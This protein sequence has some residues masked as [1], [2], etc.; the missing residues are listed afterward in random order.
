MVCVCVCIPRRLNRRRRR[1]KSDFV[2]NAKSICSETSGQDCLFA[3][4]G[5]ADSRKVAPSTIN[6]YRGSFFLVFETSTQSRCSLS[7]SLSLRTCSFPATLHVRAYVRVYALRRASVWMRESDPRLADAPVPHA[8]LVQATSDAPILRKHLIR[9]SLSLSMLDARV[10]SILTYRLLS[11]SRRWQ[12]SRRARNVCAHTQTRRRRISACFTRLSAHEQRG[13]DN[14]SC[15]NVNT[16][17]RGV[18]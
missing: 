13:G 17:L 6:I 15:R 16:T 2:E 11:V 9:R 12:I 1:V 5:N 10:V 8:R 4:V 3:N 7:L 14:N 18:H